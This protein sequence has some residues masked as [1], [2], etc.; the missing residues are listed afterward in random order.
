MRQ[1]LGDEGE[2]KRWKQ[3]G[4]DGCSR[5]D[6]R[7]EEIS[8]SQKNCKRAGEGEAPRFPLSLYVS[9]SYFVS[10]PEPRDKKNQEKDKIQPLLLNSF[11]FR[12]IVLF[13]LDV[14]AEP[15]LRTGLHVQG[16]GG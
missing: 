4:E 13:T 5:W 16:C 2:P 10:N 15:Q 3:E 1:E 8:G 7:E 14:S 6:L 12:P 11:Q 9:V